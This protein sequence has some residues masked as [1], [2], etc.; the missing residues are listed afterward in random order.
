MTVV[1]GL[2]EGKTNWVT[3][4]AKVSSGSLK[5]LS[6][7]Q[8]SVFGTVATPTSLQISTKSPFVNKHIA[9]Q[10]DVCICHVICPQVYLAIPSA[11]RRLPLPFRLDP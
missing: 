10:L 8:E 2:A 4:T 1:W 7:G 9:E 11:S 3:M 6:I 5:N